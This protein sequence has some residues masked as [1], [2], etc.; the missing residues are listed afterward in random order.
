MKKTRLHFNEYKPKI[1]PE[2]N[3]T[4]SILPSNLQ[5]FKQKVLS[6]IGFIVYK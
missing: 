6:G 4:K 1:K 3:N 2:T 5:S